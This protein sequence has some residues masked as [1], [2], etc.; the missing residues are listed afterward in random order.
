M[1][2]LFQK[3]KVPGLVVLAVALAFGAW[4]GLT[5]GDESEPLL[6]T[7]SASDE[8]IGDRD[9]VETLLA[10]RSVSVSGTILSDPAFLGLKDFGTEI[11]AEPVG[12]SN[13]FAPLSPDVALPPATR[14]A[15]LFS[16][17]EQP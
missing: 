12:R 11:I 5:G 14:G 16:P 10:L 2:A 9:L 6:T 1:D 7:E 8:T 15:Q 3:F 17:Q 4:W 13:P